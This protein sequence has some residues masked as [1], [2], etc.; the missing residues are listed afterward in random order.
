MRRLLILTFVVYSSITF[1]QDDLNVYYFNSNKYDSC[2]FV[3]YLEE[4]KFEISERSWSYG[5]VVMGFEPFSKGSV[6]FDDHQIK[7]YDPML[8]RK[9]IFF[10]LSDSILIANKH[11]AVFVKGDTLKR[12]R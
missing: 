7:C 10:Q 4:K 5:D 12:C 9:Y 3:L 8:K 2:E 11:T 1:S 6:V